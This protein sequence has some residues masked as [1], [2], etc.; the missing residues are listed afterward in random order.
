[1]TKFKTGDVVKRPEGFVVG[2]VIA[3]YEKPNHS[4]SSRQLL[5]V[6]W[7]TG[8]IGYLASQQVVLTSILFSVKQPMPKP[9]E[10]REPENHEQ[11]W[12]AMEFVC[13]GCG[14]FVCGWCEGGSDDMP[15]HCDKCWAKAHP[16][17]V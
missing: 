1:M 14:R 2:I 7:S 12:D 10:C 11:D 13:R 15:D 9:P 6:R 8:H 4:G 17:G 3:V 16:K 5:K